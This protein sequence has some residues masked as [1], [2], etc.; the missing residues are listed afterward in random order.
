LLKNSI[1]QWAL[2]E[3]LVDAGYD[4]NDL[5]VGQAGKVVAPDLYV[6]IGI[7]G[8]IRTSRYEEF[9]GNFGH[10][11]RRGRAYLWCR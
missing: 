6:A 2:L 7:S 10:Q 3:L 1:P 11:Q 4:P 8:V 5:Q 9:K